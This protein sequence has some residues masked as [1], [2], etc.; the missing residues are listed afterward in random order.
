MHP[1]ATDFSL[2]ATHLTHC[3]SAL[4]GRVDRCNGVW[5]IVFG[6]DQHEAPRN[7]RRRGNVVGT[8]SIDPRNAVVGSNCVFDETRPY[9]LP[10]V[11]DR[12][13]VGCVAVFCRSRWVTMIQAFYKKTIKRFYFSLY[14]HY[15]HNSFSHSFGIGI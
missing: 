12:C 3:F 13:A 2:L 8:I 10:T 7:R 14:T 4:F 11:A 9:R 15:H 1:P 6:A 5:N